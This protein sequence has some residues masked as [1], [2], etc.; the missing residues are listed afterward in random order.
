MRRSRAGCE[1]GEKGQNQRAR[2]AHLLSLDQQSPTPVSSAMCQNIW[3]C[4]DTREMKTE[5]DLQQDEGWIA[6]LDLVKKLVNHSRFLPVAALHRCMEEALVNLGE[7]KV[8]HT[9]LTTLMHCFDCLPP[10][11]NTSHYY[12]ELMARKRPHVDTLVKKWEFDPQEPWVFFE[13]MVEKVL[14]EE[15]SKDSEGAALCLQLLVQLLE[16]DMQ[17]WFN[18]QLESDN[19]S[20]PNWR[21]LLSHIL[22][23]QSSVSWG[24]RMEHLCSL[25]ARFEDDC[26]SLIKQIPAE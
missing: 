4:L 2:D 22:F 1:L 26:E 21:P 11:P 19:L 5:L 20:I 9:A 8:R 16:K 12:L 18:M 3:T 14:K 10:S 23:P 25:Y 13:S 7:V 15:E 17:S 6:A 24:R